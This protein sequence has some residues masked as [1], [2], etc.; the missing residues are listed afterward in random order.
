MS[1]ALKLEATPAVVCLTGGFVHV[2]VVSV[3]DGWVTMER[4]L[5][6]EEYGGNAGMGGLYNGKHNDTKLVPQ[7]T[8]RAPVIS[9]IHLMPVNVEAWPELTEAGYDKLTAKGKK[10]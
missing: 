4:T 2:A 9:L 3:A 8:L 7:Y 6:V 1:T 10:K 5:N